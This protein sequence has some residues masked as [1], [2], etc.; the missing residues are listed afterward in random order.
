[1]LRRVHV[2]V[3]GRVQGVGFRA[4]AWERALSLELSGW[5]RNLADD[6]VEIVAEGEP[7]KVA[8]FLTWCHLGPSAA[9]VDGCE[10]VEEPP[11][12]ERGFEIRRSG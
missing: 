4:A 9:R 2:W 12:G 1:M 6:R 5:V 8:E 10:V 3:S 11:T 7:G